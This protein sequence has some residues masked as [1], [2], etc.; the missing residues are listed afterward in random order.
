MGPLRSEYISL[1]LLIYSFAQ[2]HMSSE[3]QVKWNNQMLHT[4]RGAKAR[5]VSGTDF[6]IL[7]IALT[8]P[9][10][11]AAEFKL[12]PCPEWTGK[13]RKLSA[14]T[15]SLCCSCC[16][17]RGK[18]LERPQGVWLHTRMH[19]HTCTLT[20]EQKRPNRPKRIRQAAVFPVN[21][22]LST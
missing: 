9:G 13:D 3:S 5:V 19:T 15:R 2:S 20:Q 6:R 16:F 1:N 10:G 4:A 8:D 11:K 17:F 14:L 22:I 18:C 21:I 12:N 7:C